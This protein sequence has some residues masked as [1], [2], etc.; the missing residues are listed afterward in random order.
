MKRILTLFLTILTVF[1]ISTEV[2]A[3]SGKCYNC[4][5]TYSYTMEYEQWGETYHLIRHWCS[6]CNEDQYMGTN[7]ERHTMSD[8]VCT[9]CGY[10]DGSG[11]GGEGGGGSETCDH[12]Y[13]S[14]DWNGCDWKEYCDDC[15]ELID[16]GT[17]HGRT[18][19]RW[20]GCYWEDYCNDCG[21]V[22]DSGYEH[23]S[24][25]YTFW[26]YYDDTYHQR[27]YSCDVC[28]EGD[29]ELGGHITTTMYAQHSETQHIYGKYCDLCETMVEVTSYFPHNF[30]VGAWDHYSADQ[31][32]RERNC[33]DCGYSD[34]EFEN[35]SFSYG[36]WQNFNSSQ[37]RRTK[38]CPCS[39]DDYEYE[40]HS[41]I[42]GS[43]NSISDTHHQRTK[44]CVCG[45][46]TTETGLHTD[47]NGD[48]KCDGC[49]YSM[50]VTVYWNASANGGEGSTTTSVKKG[51]YAT[52]PADATKVGY[53]FKGWY[54]A[55]S[56][57]NLYNTVRINSETTFY[58]QFE[59][60][61]YTITWETHSGES[62][63]T[64]QTYGEEIV[65]PDEPR[66]SGYTFLGWYTS[67]VGGFLV[68]EGTTYKT[69][70]ESTYYAH[71]EEVPVMF[72]VTVPAVLTLTVS[73]NGEVFS[74]VNAEIVN[75]STDSVKVVQ[76]TVKT[77]NGW[78]LVPFNCNMADEKVDSKK[79]GFVL[80]NAETTQNGST[81]NLT[82]T[83]N[84]TITTAGTLPLTYDA[85]VS[86]MSA[87]VKEQVLTLVF[88]L[89]WAA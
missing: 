71:W 84:W 2:L 18:K 25:T 83:E 50:G 80:R 10:S 61:T 30:T 55:I 36:S 33:S 63:T 82:L 7:S 42:N 45:Y 29:Y 17:T 6:N 75:N 44:S 26:E 66:R 52:A 81:E 72:S 37:H 3:A 23:S 78:K 54:T 43:W 19:T 56:G 67:E 1:S 13:T 51:E 21:E 12:R 8:G 41:L 73:E 89:D 16:R 47:T 79:I 76:V 62:V 58:A 53:S 88:V 20:D 34:Y 22:F 9:K 85:V 60:K 15:G 74:A 35:H 40:N 32:R 49:G 46:S 48:G 70:G 27:Q 59:P 57:G 38:T 86:A 14:K 31:H 87:P 68:D 77:E 4:D 64:E 69:A 28:G 24:Y 11:G 39:Y 65:F 5:G